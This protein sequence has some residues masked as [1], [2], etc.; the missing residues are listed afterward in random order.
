[1]FIVNKYKVI[2]EQL[3]A[4]YMCTGSGH[5]S[6]H[7]AFVHS[8]IRGT[9]RCVCQGVRG[10]CVTWDDSILH[11]HAKMTIIFT[12]PTIFSLHVQ[13]WFCHN[14]FVSCYFD[15]VVTLERQQWLDC[16]RCA[17]IDVQL[18]SIPTCKWLQIRTQSW[19]QLRKYYY[20]TTMFFH[21]LSVVSK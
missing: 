8:F 21:A 18:I 9:F 16:K 3:H 12:T 13:P 15:C 6:V 4:S 1:M 19:L 7:S 20:W 10:T 17:V 14:G 11:V 5:L 2:I